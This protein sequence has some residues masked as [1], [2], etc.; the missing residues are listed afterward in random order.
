MQDFKR[1]VVENF[2]LENVDVIVD[3]F[4]RSGMG[5]TEVLLLGSR[6]ELPEKKIGPSPSNFLIETSVLHGFEIKLS[7][8]FKLDRFSFFSEKTHQ[9]SSE[10]HKN[11]VWSI[12]GVSLLLQFP[13]GIILVFAG[14]I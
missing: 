10:C 4:D 9:K 1:V 11:L 8:V 7:N 6:E 2:A 14:R 13:A 3:I 5:N 12:N